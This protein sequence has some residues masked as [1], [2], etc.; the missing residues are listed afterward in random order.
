MIPL[1]RYMLSRKR[2]LT[3][4]PIRTALPIDTHLVLQLHPQLR[5]ILWVIFVCPPLT[6]FAELMQYKFHPKS[7]PVSRNLNYP[8]H[9]G[10]TCLGTEQLPTAA[11][12]IKHQRDLGR[13]QT[14]QLTLQAE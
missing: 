7:H 4:F 12:V 9:K 5:A 10:M 11:A 3:L 6:L 13:I 8:L 14:L 1:S 2:R